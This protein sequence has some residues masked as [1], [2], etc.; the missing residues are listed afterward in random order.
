VK[1]TVPDTPL[2]PLA[3]N[4][5][6]AKTAE[7]PTDKLGAATKLVVVA[8]VFEVAVIFIEARIPPLSFDAFT[9]R[10]VTPGFCGVHV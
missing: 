8:V 4:T 9:E 1:V 2:S 3:A 5:N 6:A 10:F 7:V